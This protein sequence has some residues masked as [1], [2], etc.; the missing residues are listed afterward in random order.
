M[1]KVDNK[2]TRVRSMTPFIFEHISHLYSSAFITDIEQVNSCRVEF[3]L[4]KQT[5]KARYKIK[6]NMSGMLIVI[7][8]SRKKSLHIALKCIMIKK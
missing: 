6:E 4:M 1:L 3:F 2:D 7:T 5:Q 8:M